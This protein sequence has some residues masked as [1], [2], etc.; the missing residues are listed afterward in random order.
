MALL[1]QVSTS[2]PRV[3]R[4][5]FARTR[6]FMLSTSFLPLHGCWLLHYDLCP[7]HSHTDSDRL[8]RTIWVLSLSFHIDSIFLL[9]GKKRSTFTIFFP[10]HTSLYS[11]IS[12]NIPYP[13]SCTLFPKCR[14][15]VIYPKYPCGTIIWFS[16]LVFTTVPFIQQACKV[17]AGWFHTDCHW[18]QAKA[19]CWLPV[20]FHG[21][22]F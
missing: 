8:F 4:D 9:E 17:F 11:N 10:F 14:H 13:L 15:C 7:F 12:L 22:P 5:S 18:F 1:S 6:T 16:C 2:Y 20:F 19:F 3:P 21:D